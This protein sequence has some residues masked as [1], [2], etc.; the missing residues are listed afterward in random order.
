MIRVILFIS[1]RYSAFPGNSYGNLDLVFIA[2][3][4]INY[5][6]NIHLLFLLTTCFNF[7]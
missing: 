7:L 2:V 1:S 6:G 4:V 3:S 5:E